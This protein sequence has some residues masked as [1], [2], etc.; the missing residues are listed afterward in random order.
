MCK[1]EERSDEALRIPRQGAARI[2]ITRTRALGNLTCKGDSFRPSLSLSSR[3]HRSNVTNISSF[4]TR[5][6]RRSIEADYIHTFFDNMTSCQFFQG[7]F[8]REKDGALKVTIFTRNER[9]WR[10]AVGTTSRSGCSLICTFGARNSQ[11]G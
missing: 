10:T 1:R 4:A 6:A 5:F 3:L 7:R 2:E 8:L 9:K 11:P